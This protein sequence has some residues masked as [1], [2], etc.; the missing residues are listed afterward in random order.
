MSL[1]IPRVLEITYNQTEGCH[2]HIHSIVASKTEPDWMTGSDMNPATDYAVEDSAL[3]RLAMPFRE[4]D[5][6]VVTSPKGHEGRGA[7][8]HVCGAGSWTISHC[9]RP[10]CLP[11]QKKRA[12]RYYPIINNAL[13]AG[14]VVMKRRHR[15]T[16]RKYAYRFMTVTIKSVPDGHLHRAVRKAEKAWQDLR[17]S[18]FWKVQCDV[19][20]DIPRLEITYDQT[21]G[22]HVHIHSIVAS[23]FVPEGDL[24]NPL[25]FK[26]D[27]DP[28]HPQNLRDQWLA[29]TGDS[30]IVDVRAITSPV[31]FTR[32]LVKYVF[33]PTDDKK[34][35]I[36]NWPASARRELAETLVGPHRMVWYCPT[37]HSRDRQHCVDHVTPDGYTTVE[38]AGAYRLERQGF[39]P[40]EPSGMFRSEPTR[41]KKIPSGWMVEVS[42]ARN[43]KRAKFKSID[44]GF[45]VWFP[46]W[47]GLIA[48]AKKE[49]RKP[50][51]HQCGL[52]ESRGRQYW[53]TY[54]GCN[55]LNASHA[56]NSIPEH[57]IAG[58]ITRTPLDLH[59][60]MP[61][62]WKPPPGYEN[63][64][65][66]MRQHVVD[67]V[68]VRAQ[69]EL[70]IAE[71][72]QSLFPDDPVDVPRLI[73]DS[74]ANLHILDK[75]PKTGQYHLNETMLARLTWRN[76]GK[77]SKPAR[78]P[79]GE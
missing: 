75:H 27:P 26:G 37:H 24:F 57:Q 73:V 44:S 46:G 4:L 17:R 6:T 40:L 15:A 8:C 2:V 3:R 29:L 78:T 76:S 69:D 42:S 31:S 33:K 63:F 68:R 25:H 51:C 34:K 50:S 43:G 70:E 35:N 10:L 9:G 7:V 65:P 62:S 5:D 28:K 1:G 11:C 54:I 60:H 72:W 74:L 79:G 18:T 38:C 19:L 45:R 55:H 21:E 39:H 20:G 58:R 14:Q 71:V 48:A 16:N 53:K 23:K 67:M 47:L 59:Y 77:V 52:G 13:I 30:I 49:P 61:S 36:S 64:R 41:A 66:W 12:A 32:E 56:L 22:W